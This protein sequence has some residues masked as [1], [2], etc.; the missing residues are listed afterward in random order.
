MDLT[1]NF[2]TVGFGMIA[3]THLMAMQANLALHPDE[4][5][6]RPYAL[7]TRRPKECEGLPYDVIYTDIDELVAD[8]AVQVVDVCTPN[9]LHVP[10]AEAAVNA[11]K[12]IYVEKPISDNM[13][14]ALH[15]CKLVKDKGIPNQVALM[16]RFRH[17]V[18]RTKDLLDA[19]VIGEPIHFRCYFFHSS[20]LDP[21]RPTS[22]RQTLSQAGGGGLLD[23]GIHMVDLMR[24]LLGREVTSLDAKLRTINKQRYTSAE[25]T[26]TVANETDE[27]ACLSMLLEGGV[28]GVLESS[29]ISGSAFADAAFEVFGTGGSLLLTLIGKDGILIKKNGVVS[30]PD[31]PPGPYETALKHLLPDQR[32]SMSP[33]INAHAAA[34]QNISRMAVKQ[35]GFIGTPTLDEG[36]KAQALVTQSFQTAVW[37]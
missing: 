32:Q 26:D 33:F 14:G 31:S 3:R 13:D 24:Y 12:T 6:G 5:R 22:W 2:G 30:E 17:D 21:K 15:L 16:M 10:V 8:E 7:C 1:V 23:L 25:S 18:N 19:G 4:P 37:S 20:Y 35:P 27:Y 11:G 34:L 9:H 36:A 29:R 28:V